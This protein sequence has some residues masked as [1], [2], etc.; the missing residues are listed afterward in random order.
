M[1]TRLLTSFGLDALESSG[2]RTELGAKWLR[3]LVRRHIMGLLGE[4]ERFM[5]IEMSRKSTEDGVSAGHR[6]ACRYCRLISGGLGRNAKD[7]PWN[8]LLCESRNFMVMPTLGP[9]VEGWL[10]IISREHHLCMGAMPETVYGELEEIIGEVG[11]VVADQYVP[12][13][14]FEHGPSV[15]GEGIGCGIDHAHVHVV[16]LHFSLGDALRRS[17]EFR[18]LDWKIA[19]EGFLDC[20]RLSRARKPYVFVKEPQGSATYCTMPSLPCQAVRRV[21]AR[22][23]G[24]EGEYD[25]NR[26]SHIAY[27]R[28]TLERIE[29]HLDRRSPRAE[30]EWLESP[31]GE[32]TH[33][34]RICTS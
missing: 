17:A 25:Y 1:I 14:I 11:G 8:S 34:A 6:Q 30:R 15:H 19:R 31:D 5:R 13:T 26:Y 18:E 3:P 28:R 7:E 10:L 2:Y 9:L 23:V 32:T 22:E 16:P 27:V 24:L 4:E 12:P 20:Q 33:R 29:K 21:I